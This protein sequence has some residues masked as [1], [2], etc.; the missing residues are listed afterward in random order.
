MFHHIHQ[1]VANFVCLPFGAEYEVYIR[2]LEGFFCR[3]ENQ[4]NK[5]TRITT[6]RLYAS[7]PGQAPVY[8][9]VCPDSIRSTVSPSSQDGGIKKT[10]NKTLYFCSYSK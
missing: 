2:V 10:K 1:L 8:V 6:L 4:N 3:L 5:L 7:P 9:H